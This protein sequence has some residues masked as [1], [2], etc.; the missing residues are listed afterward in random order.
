MIGYDTTF[1]KHGRATAR[2][3][4]DH[5]GVEVMALY[6]AARSPTSQTPSLCS[7][8]FFGCGQARNGNGS[9]LF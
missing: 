1:I 5:N 7:P 9:I 2:A 3:I 6:L 4:G 8:A